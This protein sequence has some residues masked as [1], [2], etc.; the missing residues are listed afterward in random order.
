VEEMSY[1]DR[2]R[3]PAFAIMSRGDTMLTV[4]L[5]VL[6]IM[7]F[8]GGFALPDPHYRYGGGALGLILLIL[9]ICMV[10][11]VVHG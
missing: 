7:C 1:F 5:V 3:G 11:G 10:L 4:I 6:I 8:G 9:L 2:T